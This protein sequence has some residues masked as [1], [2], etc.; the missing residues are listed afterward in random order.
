MRY[1]NSRI[2]MFVAMAL[3]A[4][5]G[6]AQERE[7]DTPIDRDSYLPSSETAPRSRVS[8]RAELPVTTLEVTVSNEREESGRAVA[9][10]R[11]QTTLSITAK[12]ES[13]AMLKGQ[14][15]ARVSLSGVRS[16][17]AIVELKD[18]IG[19]IKFV[20]PSGVRDVE[21]LIETGGQRQQGRIEYSAELRPLLA[22][23]MV[24]TVFNIDRRQSGGLGPMAGLSDGLERELRNWERRFNGGKSSVAGQM[25]FFVKGSVGNDTAVTAMFDS[26]KDI[27]QR[28]FRD[29]NP[30]RSYPVMGD[31][32]ERG[33]ESRSSDR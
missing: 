23:G 10:G 13:G 14:S 21:W 4:A 22:V 9:D 11:S 27:R 7:F 2:S 33:F 20:T 25:S 8:T 15:F 31:S 1:F 3:V 18:G 26:E 32:A 16:P 30:D 6:Q 12:D 17:E 28:E 24:E 19:E 29:Y 5:S